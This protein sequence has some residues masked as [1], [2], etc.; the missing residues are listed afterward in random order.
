MYKRYELVFLR[1]RSVSFLRRSTYEHLTARH[2]LVLVRSSF[3]FFS[4]LF[5]SVDYVRTNT[6]AYA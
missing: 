2:F 3:S 6:F 1:S 4:F 5:T